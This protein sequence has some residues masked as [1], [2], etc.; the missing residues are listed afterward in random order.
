LKQ[1]GAAGCVFAARRTPRRFASVAVADVCA[2]NKDF[3][4][5]QQQLSA[6][7]TSTRCAI[8]KGFLRSHTSLLAQ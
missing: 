4:R 6:Q 8:G 3:L 2:I 5:N 7:S 1:I